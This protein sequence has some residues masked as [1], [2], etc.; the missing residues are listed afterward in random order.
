MDYSGGMEATPITT[1]IAGTADQELYQTERFGMNSSNAASAFNYNIPL[2]NGT[3]NVVLKFSENYF[4]NAGARQF[5][6]ALNS[7]TVLTNFDIFATA[8][9]QYIAVDKEFT[10][11]VTNGALS[12]AFTPGAANNPKIDAIAVIT[13]QTATGASTPSSPTPVPT[14]VAAMQAAISQNTP[15]MQ[16]ALPYGVPTSYSWSNGKSGTMSLTPAPSGFT[17]MTAWG[18]V[19][20]NAAYS[21]IAFSALQNWKVYFSNYTTYLHVAGT[22]NWIVAQSQNESSNPLVLDGFT[23]NYQG[24]PNLPS[25]L[26]ATSVATNEASGPASGLDASSNAFNW[27]FWPQNRASYTA[28]TIDGVFVSVEIMYSGSSAPHLIANLGSDWW[29]NTSA[30]FAVVN[31]VDVNNPG[32]G[33]SNWVVVTNQWQTLYF[34]SLSNAQL[35]ANPPPPLQ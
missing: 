28:G 6:V 31:G 32:V 14:S 19:Y 35:Q 26:S 12:I 15:G 7:Q 11:N 2:A 8:G 3:Y 13:S 20:P 22:S 27:N 16:Q 34:Y 4:T 30:P 29:L 21:P 10:V 5:N 9:G 1:A 25:S 17:S 33:E 24:S 18:Q 23:A